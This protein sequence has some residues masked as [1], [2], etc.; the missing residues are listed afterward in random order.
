MIGPHIRR[1]VIAWCC[2]AG[3]AVKSTHTSDDS[4]SIL[5]VDFV[6]SV[7]CVSLLSELYLSS[8]PED[9]W[10]HSFFSWISLLV[11]F[12]VK[13]LISLPLLYEFSFT[14]AIQFCSHFFFF[15]SMF[16]L[17]FKFH[18]FC[19]IWAHF[20]WEENLGMWWEERW[21]LWFRLLMGVYLSNFGLVMEFVIFFLM[22]KSI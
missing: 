2:R 13:G 17:W 20:L 10:N 3:T 22:D 18:L 5:T 9:A 6:S 21:C 8:E 1:K 15:N 12:I 11:L 4:N 16:F 14:I 7:L 19:K